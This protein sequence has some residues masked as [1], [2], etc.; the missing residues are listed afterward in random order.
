MTIVEKPRTHKVVPSLRDLN[1]I[2]DAQWRRIS[3]VELVVRRIVRWFK[4]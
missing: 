1:N 2:E 3:K 4:Y